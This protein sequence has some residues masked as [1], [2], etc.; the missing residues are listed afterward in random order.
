MKTV[1]FRN[2]A[3][4]FLLSALLGVMSGLLVIA[5]SFV[6]TEDGLLP[7]FSSSTFCVWF[8]TCSLIA[9]LSD[10]NGTAG[11]HTAVYVMCLITV[12]CIISLFQCVLQRENPLHYLRRE[13]IWCLLLAVL[14]AVMCYALAFILNF[15]RMHNVLGVIIRFL[16]A[17]IIALDE[18]SCIRIMLTDHRHIA[19]T[20][21]QGLCLIAYIV[22]LVILQIKKPAQIFGQKATI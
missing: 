21:M 2:D 10:D 16:P 17:V 7:Y 9:L 8:F 15:G 14:A 5:L 19:T 11:Y 3:R 4:S 1:L 22:I 6:T 13:L 12:P 18:A 20:V